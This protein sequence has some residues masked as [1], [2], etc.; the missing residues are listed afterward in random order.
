M[1]FISP[2]RIVTEIMKDVH[3]KR[4][5]VGRYCEKIVPAILATKTNFETLKKW[6]DDVIKKEFQTVKSIRWMLFMKRRNSNK[7]M[8]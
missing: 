1:E 8:R 3:A 7:I 6:L 4:K 5:K 2:V